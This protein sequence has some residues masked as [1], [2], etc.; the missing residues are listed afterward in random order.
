MAAQP[1]VGVM[2]SFSW[3]S[4]EHA[5]CVPC[6]ETGPDGKAVVDSSAGGELVHDGKGSGTWAYF[7]S[8]APLQVGQAACV[9][10]HW[11]TEAP[12]G[13]QVLRVGVCGQG[14]KVSSGLQMG[15]FEGRKP[16]GSG[17]A[18]TPAC[19]VDTSSSTVLCCFDPRMGD[20]QGSA[21]VSSGGGGGGG[22]PGSAPLKICGMGKPGTYC[23]PSTVCR[24][25][26]F[27]L[28]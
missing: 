11:N 3:E 7:R 17:K 22:T 1:S 15:S 27:A 10:C 25:R 20:V 18:A 19:A 28:N 13:E 26:L 14:W 8:Q 2:A 23:L 12:A 9:S 21:V 16:D 24:P 4:N 6:E 5:V